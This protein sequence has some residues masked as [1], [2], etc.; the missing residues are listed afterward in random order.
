MLLNYNMLSGSL[1][2][3]LGSTKKLVS[4]HFYIPNQLYYV[5]AVI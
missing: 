1:E 5:L 2:F 4:V 3:Q